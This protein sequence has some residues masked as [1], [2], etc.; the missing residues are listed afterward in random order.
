MGARTE[1]VPFDGPPPNPAVGKS[2]WSAERPV[3]C[4]MSAA[5][6]ELDYQALVSYAESLPETVEWLAERLADGRDW[7]DA[8]PQLAGV[9]PDL[10]DYAAEDA[11]LAAEG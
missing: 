4:D 3:V 8:F 2:P 9:Y 11:W 6:R 5:E 10:F 7:R 1:T